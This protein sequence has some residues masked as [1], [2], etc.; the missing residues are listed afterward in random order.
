MLSHTTR[1]SQ[2]SSLADDTDVGIMGAE[3]EEDLAVVGSGDARRRSGECWRNRVQQLCQLFE[4]RAGANSGSNVDAH[5]QEDGP[6]EKGM[7]EAAQGGVSETAS[8]SHGPTQPGA[9]GSKGHI[10]QQGSIAQAAV[11]P[12]GVFEGRELQSLHQ[13]VGSLQERME[14]MQVRMEELDCLASAKCQECASLLISNLR[15]CLE[16]YIHALFQENSKEL[17][18]QAAALLADSRVPTAGSEGNAGTMERCNVSWTSSRLEKVCDGHMPSKGADVKGEA[19]RLIRR[20]A[21]EMKEAIPEVLRESR[22]S[23]GELLKQAL[24]REELCVTRRERSYQTAI[25]ASAD[26]GATQLRRTRSVD[27]MCD[28]YSLE[29]QCSSIEPDGLELDSSITTLPGTCVPHS[30]TGRLREKLAKIGCMDIDLVDESLQALQMQVEAFFVELVA[31]ARLNALCAEVNSVAA[32]LPGQS[33]GPPTQW[34]SGKPTQFPL[35]QHV[36]TK[37]GS[38]RIETIRPESIQRDS[39]P[40]GSMQ[41]KPSRSGSTQL[42]RGRPAQCVIPGL[43]AGC[44][45][46]T[47][48]ISTSTSAPSLGISPVIPVQQSHHLVRDAPSHSQSTRVVSMPDAALRTREVPLARSA[49]A[50]LEVSFGRASHRAPHSVAGPLCRQVRRTFGNGR[51]CA[52]PVSAGHSS[53]PLMVLKDSSERPAGTNPLYMT[54]GAPSPKK[55]HQTGLVAEP[56]MMIHRSTVLATRSCSPVRMTAAV[57]MG[58]SGTLPASDL[59]HQSLSPP[60]VRRSREVLHATHRNGSTSDRRLG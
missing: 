58:L 53:T 16:A 56:R 25:L 28:P 55:E 5:P 36:V 47:R 10:D 22:H 40:T 33:L 21:A 23:H 18:K 17:M 31:K 38:I 27:F 59:Q 14:A 51:S 48:H 13:L 44:L 34:N 42:E 39:T 29:M 45:P 15:E 41:L 3:L 20:V 32:E 6:Q 37:T 19:D 11:S 7:Q 2:A 24:Q 52:G 35:S 49:N 46:I 4:D 9:A 1:G 60:P 57:P 26:V 43:A 12:V 54:D 50:S 30:R 8:S